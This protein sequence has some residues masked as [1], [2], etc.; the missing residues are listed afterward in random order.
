ME[1]PGVFKNCKS[2]FQEFIKNNMEFPEVIK[3]KTCG[4]SRGLGFRPYNF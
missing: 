3:K 4:I 1:F 2:I